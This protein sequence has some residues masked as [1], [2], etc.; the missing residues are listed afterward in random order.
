MAVD[1]VIGDNMGASLGGKA[2]AEALSSEKRSSI[3][4]EGGK[5]RANEL[6]PERRSE[7]ASQGGKAKNDK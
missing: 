7:I 6:S 5:A 4:G 1:K 2:R 3:A